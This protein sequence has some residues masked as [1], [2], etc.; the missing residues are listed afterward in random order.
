MVISVTKGHAS[1]CWK[2]GFCDLTEPKAGYFNLKVP[3]KTFSCDMISKRDNL[4]QRK[5][6]KEKILDEDRR[7][8]WS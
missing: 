5:Y 8:K 3:I 7:K 2:V 6:L 1:P 4:P